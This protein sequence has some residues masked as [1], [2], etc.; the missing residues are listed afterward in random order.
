MGSLGHIKDKISYTLF[1]FKKKPPITPLGFLISMKCNRGA[2][3]IGSRFCYS[4]LA[5]YVNINT[6]FFKS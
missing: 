2:Y 5:V 4:V 6:F 3:S 1:S